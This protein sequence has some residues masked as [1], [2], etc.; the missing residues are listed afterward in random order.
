MMILLHINYLCSETCLC[1]LIMFSL[2]FEYGLYR[3]IVASLSACVGVE[4]AAGWFIAM[5]V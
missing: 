3:A 1:R 5:H 4:F 2:V